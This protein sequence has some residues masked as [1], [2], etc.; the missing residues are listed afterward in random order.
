MLLRKPESPIQMVFFQLQ[1]NRGC[2]DV[3]DWLADLYKC[4]TADSYDFTC[5]CTQFVHWTKVQQGL[6]QVLTHNSYEK[7]WKEG[8][9]L[10]YQEDRTMMGLWHGTQWYSH[11][12]RGTW[13]HVWK[14]WRCCS[15]ELPR[16]SLFWSF[17]MCVTVSQNYIIVSVDLSICVGGG[18]TDEVLQIVLKLWCKKQT[19]ANRVWEQ[20]WFKT[21]FCVV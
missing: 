18:C 20:L 3:P 9:F 14:E 11:H 7:G 13:W 5:K 8:S 15:L 17:W 10:D 19:R 12:W 16:C 6:M 21:N 4:T 1:A 2:S